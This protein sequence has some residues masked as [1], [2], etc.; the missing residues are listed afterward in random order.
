MSNP[1]LSAALR[2][3]AYV[4]L[5]ILAMICYS[6]HKDK[7]VARIKRCLR[8]AVLVA[9]TVQQDSRLVWQEFIF[10]R[11]LTKGARAKMDLLDS[12]DL[13]ALCERLQTYLKGLLDFLSFND[14]PS[15]LCDDG[16]LRVDEILYQHFVYGIFAALKD[17]LGFDSVKSNRES[18]DGRYDIS[19]EARRQAFVIELKTAS[20]DEDLAARANEAL[21]QIKNKRYAAEFPGKFV[22]A[23]GMS[24]RKKDCA[25]AAEEIR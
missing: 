23:I 5:A 2:L 10:S 3:T 4:C 6:I 7:G 9:L 20:R 12:D 22:V 14:L 17:S 16:K 25:V 19:I 8:K 24:F 21:K 1:N 13:P 15:S 11:I 18:G